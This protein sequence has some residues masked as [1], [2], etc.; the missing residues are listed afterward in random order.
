MRSFARKV[1]VSP[2]AMSE[3]LSGKR[4]VSLEKAIQ[5]L[6]K[7]GATLEQI[8]GIKTTAIAVEESTRFLLPAEAHKLVTQWHY[9]AILSV[10][11]TCT[12]PE[13]LEAL[14]SRLGLSIELATKA[15]SDL[16]HFE[17]LKEKKPG[18]FVST[19]KAWRTTDGIASQSI[20]D[21]HMDGLE[22]SRRALKDLPVDQ[23][24]FISLTFCA[25]SDNFELARKEIRRFKDRLAKIMTKSPKIDSVF[26]LGVQLFP[27]DHWLNRN[28]SHKLSDSPMENQSQT[29]P[30]STN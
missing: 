17:L 5:I 20:V 4:N 2:G 28:T 23:R 24:D 16:V 22:L 15:T 3:I 6:E 8:N 13:S 18:L 10:Y 30:H 29:P 9:F 25:S 11:D 26:R 21:S 19:K 12:P 27:V 14:A 1:D 7:A